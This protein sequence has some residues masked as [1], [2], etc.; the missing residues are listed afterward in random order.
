MEG[1]KSQLRTLAILERGPF[2]C[3]QDSSCGMF[4]AILRVMKRARKSLAARITADL[5]YAESAIVATDIV[6]IAVSEVE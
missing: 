6:K 1:I 4:T 2:E 5:T 3:L